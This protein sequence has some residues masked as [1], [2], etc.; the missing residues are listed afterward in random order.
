[1]RKNEELSR[2]VAEMLRKE[3]LDDEEVL[4]EFL[5]KAEIHG[6]VALMVDDDEVI[7]LALKSIDWSLVMAAMNFGDLLKRAKRLRGD[8]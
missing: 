1:M 4:S 2:A 3:L 7:E 5:T 8:M 6:W